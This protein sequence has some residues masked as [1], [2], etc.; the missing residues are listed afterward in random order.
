MVRCVGRQAARFDSTTT[1]RDPAERIAH[2]RRQPRFDQVWGDELGRQ[3]H[4][5]RCGAPFSFSLLSPRSF[6]NAAVSVTNAPLGPPDARHRPTLDGSRSDAF[7]SATMATRWRVGT[8]G[9]L[10]CGAAAGLRLQAP[11]VMPKQTT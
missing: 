6:I 3:Q 1:W 4:T 7:A 2:R 9:S 5:V 11:V 8:V 10:S